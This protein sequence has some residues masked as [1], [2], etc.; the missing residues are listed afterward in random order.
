VAE[1]LLDI[2]DAAVDLVDGVGVAVAAVA[3][4]LSTGTATPQQLG[5]LR[6]SL[7]GYRADLA[8]LRDTLDT[9]DVAEFQLY[10]G[11][12]VTIALWRW[13]RGT[14]HDLILL[15]PKLRA[16]EQVATRLVSGTTRSTVVVRSGDTLQTI[17][18]REFG[19]W[20]E[21]PRL[22]AANGLTPGALVP[23]TTLIIPPKR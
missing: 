21:W 1:S 16:A 19:S 14:R 6:S 7:T 23:G 9:T 18:A 22:A 13:E 12:A 5:A 8:E 3:S 20:Q 15:A 2:R 11:A 17:A 10:D 4:A